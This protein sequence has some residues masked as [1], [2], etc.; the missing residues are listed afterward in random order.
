MA[1]ESENMTVTFSNFLDFTGNIF[2]IIF[3][4]EMVLKLIAYGDTYFKNSWNKF[5]FVV[6]FSS[7]FDVVIK[8]LENIEADLAI[9]SSLT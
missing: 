2:S 3:F 1:V 7:L 9:L 6:V 4:I 8:L 5:D